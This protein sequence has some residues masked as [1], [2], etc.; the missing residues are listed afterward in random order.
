MLQKVHIYII[1]LDLG[2]TG[3]RSGNSVKYRQM[4]IF[5]LTKHCKICNARPRMPLVFFFVFF[6]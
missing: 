4:K 5:L 1:T 6:F 3:E 2:E